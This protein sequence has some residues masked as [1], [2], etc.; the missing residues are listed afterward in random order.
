MAP[1]SRGRVA[2][3]PI[4]FPLAPPA[5][6]MV[7]NRGYHLPAP[8]KEEAFMRR[9]L[10]GVTVILIL[11]AALAVSACNTMKGFGQ[12]LSNLGDSITGKAEKHTQK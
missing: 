6:A 4:T 3:D 5:D 12:D 7:G 11:A 2:A 1:T 10:S 8:M 9:A